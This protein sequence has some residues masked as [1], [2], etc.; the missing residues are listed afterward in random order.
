MDTPREAPTWKRY[1]PLGFVVIG[2]V[3]AFSLFRDFLNF[4]ALAEH[5]QTLVDWRDRNHALALA[6]FMGVY[7]LAVAFSLPG[8]VWLTIVGGFL[9]GTIEGSI[10]VVISAT[11]GAM[12]IF[13]VLQGRKV[14]QA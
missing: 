3:V 1:L 8:A 7:V 6:V 11:A 14:R 12:I 5:Y 4:S 9:F 2:A 13:L 10:A